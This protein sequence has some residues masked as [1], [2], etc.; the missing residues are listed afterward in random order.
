MQFECQ[1][2]G[3]LITKHFTDGKYSL[4]NS[5]RGGC[6]SRA[7]LPDRTTA[8]TTDWQRVRIQEILT[9]DQHEAGRIPRT[10][11]CELTK[12]LVDKC[13]PGDQVSICGV[14]KVVSTDQF[15]QGRMYRLL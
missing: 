6:K 7:F 12:D 4:P 9:D 2:C 10:I 13:V 5:C 8:E 1:K 3:A 11:E 14:V 15:A